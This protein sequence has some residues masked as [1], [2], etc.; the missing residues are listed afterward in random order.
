MAVLLGDVFNA[1][2]ECPEEWN[3]LPGLWHV[4]MQNGSHCE[5]ERERL[6]NDGEPC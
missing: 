6:R 5:G 3:D 1:Y 2:H 4:A